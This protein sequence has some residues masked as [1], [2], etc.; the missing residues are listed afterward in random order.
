MAD[1]ET[2]KDQWSDI[3]DRDGVRLS[4]NTFPSSLEI[5]IRHTGSFSSRRPHRCPLHTSERE[6][7][8]SATPVCACRVQSAMQGRPQPLLVCLEQSLVAVLKL[9]VT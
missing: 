1:F 8:Y 7:G 2:L 9:T 4:W 3:E 5:L 6:D